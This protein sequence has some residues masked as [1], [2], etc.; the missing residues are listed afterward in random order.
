M[1]MRIPGVI[2][3]HIVAVGMEMLTCTVVMGVK[4]HAFAQQL[5]HHPGS[6]QH[7]HQPN[8]G[9]EQIGG[10][11][12]QARL[13]EQQQATEQ[14]QGQAMPDTPGRA[15]PRRVS[16][17]ACTRAQARDG[18]EVIGIEGML[19]AEKEAEKQ[20]VK[21]GL[22]RRRRGDYSSKCAV[23]KLLSVKTSPGQPPARHQDM[24]IQSLSSKNHM[25]A[26]KK[27]AYA[28]VISSRDIT[29]PVA[30]LSR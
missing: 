18:R 29:A 5:A 2:G 17:A 27:L 21:H 20:D 11:W 24:C 1:M 13:D 23:Q 4:V 7:E 3:V 10:P 26:L 12:R 28:F 25:G 6:Q 22:T 14:Q 15:V 19:Q 8:A 9:F 30:A 16:E